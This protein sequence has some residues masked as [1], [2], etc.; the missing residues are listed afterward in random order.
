MV[1]SRSKKAV[2]NT[3]ASLFLEFISIICGFILPK[4]ILIY[5][6]STYNGV[7]AAITQ[8]L[9]YVTLLRAGVGGVTRAALYKPLSNHD[10]VEVS[11]IVKATEIFMRKI[12]YIFIGLILIFAIIFPL[13]VAEDFSWLFTFSLVLIMGIATFSQYYFGIT[14]QML[15]GADQRQYISSII[16]CITLIINLI[17]SIV[18]IKTGCGIHIVK[19]GNAIVFSLNPII[20]SIFVKRKY[21]LLKDVEPN[22][23]A[24]NQR[25]DAFMHQIAAFVQENTDI[26]VLSLFSNMNEVSVY[27]IYY[28]VSN[29]I[30]KLLETLTIGIE[31]AFGNMIALN[32]FKTLNLTLKRLETILFSIGTFCYACVINLIVSFVVVY[33]SGIHDVEYARPIFALI[34]GLAQFF[35]CIRTPYQYIVEAAG[36][37]KQTRNGAIMEAVINLTVSIILVIK[38]GLVGVAIGTLVSMIFRTIQYAYYVSKNILNR[39]FFQFLNK[40]F[41]SILNIILITFVIHNFIVI[42]ATSYLDFFINAIIVAFISCL[43]VVVSNVIFNFNSF[44]DCVVTVIKILKK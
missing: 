17:V 27:S 30:K 33:T 7:T 12:A 29:G 38:F 26:V 6:G 20:L 11:R 36:H 22:N 37:F 32:D 1:E 3:L 31:A 9:S 13:I 42:T 25:W 18:L 4:F 16:Q 2:Y 28:L 39:S 14:Y 23:Q 41:V 8:F 10:D 34:L 40:L 43:F 15:I 24:I 21:K 5:F 35:Y 19:L 44:K